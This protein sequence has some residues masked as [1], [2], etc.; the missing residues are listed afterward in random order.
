MHMYEREKG[1]LSLLLYGWW[2]RSILPF[3]TC[4]S[5]VL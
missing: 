3:F 5:L 1:Y 2:M 4:S